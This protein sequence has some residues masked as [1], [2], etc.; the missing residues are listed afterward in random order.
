[1]TKG[2]TVTGQLAETVDLYPTLASLA[3]LPAPDGPQPIDGVDLTPVLRDG[4]KRLREYAYHAY[5]RGGR[6]GLA[7]RTS[8]YRLVEWTAEGEEPVYEL[9]D[10]REDPLETRNTAT[11]EPETVKR[12]RAMLANEPDPVQPRRR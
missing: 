3:G 8:R 11:D 2:G 6:L 4:R 5:P 10:Y 12:L 9:Y 7:I 1:M